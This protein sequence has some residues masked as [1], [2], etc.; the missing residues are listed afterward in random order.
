MQNPVN[1]VM[2][3]SHEGVVENAR[4]SAGGRDVGSRGPERWV[5]VL[6]QT[7]CI[8]CH[9]CTTA[10]KSENEVPL[11]VTRT[12]VKSVDVGSYPNVRRAFQ[13]T[14]CNQ[15]ENPPCVTACPT[16]AM[17]QRADGIVDFDK[18]ICIGCKACMAACPYDA[19]FIN[20]EDHSAEKCNFCA[21]RIEIGLEPACVAVCPTEAIFIGNIKDPN[22]RVSKVVQREHV[23]VRKAEKHT[24]PGLF[25]KGAHAATLDP[26]A[27]TRPGGSTF[28]WSEL[29][30]STKTVNSG[31]P[32]KGHHNSSAAA[33]LSYDI[34]HSVPWGWKV[35]LYT[36]TKG[37]AAGFF[38]FV[39]LLSYFA[40]LS[41]SSEMTRVIG[42]VVSLV[43]LGITG[44]LLIV[45]LKHPERFYLLFT[46]PQWKSWLVRGGV[47]I[48]LYG[49]ALALSLLLGFTHNSG[50]VKD[51]GPVTIVLGA[52]TA[53]YTA[54][55]FAQS[56]ARDL[57]QSPLL[58]P[59]LL[60]QA[61]LIGSGGVALLHS[62]LSVTSYRWAADVFLTML[63]LHTLFVFAEIL[64]P[65][66]TAGAHLAVFEMTRST[67]AKFFWFGVAA[68]ALGF[69]FILS[70]LV[71]VS[72][73]LL[74]LLSY[75]HAFVQSAQRVPLA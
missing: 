55:L 23:S 64:I 21:H 7:R 40:K 29:K 67:M 9:A 14:R 31:H 66:P 72:I 34:S 65:H 11:G 45:D 25:Y 43:F 16:G 53:V 36:W 56:K 39:L 27:A 57:W 74:G 2:F 49:A 61:A 68:I 8:G 44:V 63:V 4:P 3:R 5:K 1:S 52:L 50:Y 30:D 51:L 20:P 59:M 69:L 42:P 71:G 10:C 22:S 58:G 28:M 47:I 70:P 12:Y 48:S 19:I 32:E 75:E 24:R 33:K 41:F 46:H 37:V 62:Y 15:C 38:P 18:R 35:S 60:V 54:F 6:D 26:I 13:V 17:Y 73:A